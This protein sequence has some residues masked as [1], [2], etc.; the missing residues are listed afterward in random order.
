MAENHADS[1]VAGELT[2]EGHDGEA[3]SFTLSSEDNDHEA[4]TVD[5]NGVLRIKDGVNLDYERQATYAFTVTASG[6]AN[7]VFDVTV[8]V[9]NVV[10]PPGEPRDLTAIAGGPDRIEVKWSTPA[11]L[12]ARL[13]GYTVQYKPV[14]SSQWLDHAHDGHATVTT[15]AGL[16]ARS[17]YDVRVR[18]R[19]DGDS[20]WTGVGVRTT[21]AAPERIDGFALPDLTLVIGAPTVTVDAATVLMGDDLT[22]TFT[23]SDI[24]VASFID[25]TAET[26]GSAT[27]VLQAEAPGQVQ[28]TVTATNPGGTASVT[29]AVTVKA[30]SDEEV[31]ALG[32]TLDG[33][34]RTLLASATGVISARMADSDMEAQPLPRLKDIDAAVTVAALLGMNGGPMTAGGGV[35]GTDANVV[36]VSTESDQAFTW[37]QGVAPSGG[38]GWGNAMRPDNGHPTGTGL[39]WDE[40][41]WNRS[42]TYSLGLNSEPAADGKSESNRPSSWTVWG[43]GDQQSF[44]GNDGEARYEGTWQTAY[45][46]ADRRVGERWLGG[47]ALAQRYGQ[48]DYAFGGALAGVGLLKTELTEVYPYLNGSL[49]NGTELWAML[50][51]GTGAITLERHRTDGDDANVVSRHHGDLNMRLGSAGLRHALADIHAVQFA[52]VADVGAAALSADGEHALMRQDSTTHRVRAGLEATGVGHFAPYL[53]LNGRYDGGTEKANLGYE[54]EAGL[55]YVG[56]YLDFDLSG[57]YM[58]LTGDADYRETGAAA[59]LKFKAMADGTGL[60]ATLRP[61]WGRPTSSGFVWQQDAVPVMTTQFASDPRLTLNA[62]LGYGIETWRLRGQLIPTLSVRRAEDVGNALRLGASYSAN[63]RWLRW[64]PIIGFGL[65]REQT[66]KGDAWSVELGAELRW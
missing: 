4:F 40:L 33:F 34:T 39:G 64:Q 61:S 7:D 19:G 47:I 41:L 46:G 51:A 22:F 50:G 25:S 59:T 56:R 29:F 28:V 13:D 35:P 60:F 62:E 37:N 3:R 6:G 58:A 17:A 8:T 45:L 32:Q 5:A 23:S 12:G 24:A 54:G 26:N 48:A 63:P 53:R 27:A 55:H 10:E 38:V 57:R 30:A 36:G 44:S 15:I 66:Q 16:E 49:M 42:F 9:A 2:T 43:L 20:A 21:V 1:F 14:G 31:E 11:D 18:A 52:V 65:Q